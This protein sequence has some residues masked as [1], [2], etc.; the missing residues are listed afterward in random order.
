[1]PTDHLSLALLNLNPLCPVDMIW[2]WSLWRAVFGRHSVRC[3]RG[4][5]SY[6]RFWWEQGG[7]TLTR[8]HWHLCVPQTQGGQITWGSTHCWWGN[9]LHLHTY[10]GFYYW[11]YWVYTI[12]VQISSQKEISL[13][14]QLIHIPIIENVSCFYG[15]HESDFLCTCSLLPQMLEW[16]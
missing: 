16:H 3:R 6:A 2:S 12:Y 15:H 4:D 11:Y 1:M 13:E 7:L 5:Q 10:N 8:T 9:A 14:L